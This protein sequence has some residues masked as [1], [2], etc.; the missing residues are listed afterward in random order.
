[1]ANKKNQP[2]LLKLPSVI[3]SD[4]PP[5]L[6]EGEGC[7]G[8]VFVCKM[9]LHVNARVCVFVHVIGVS[10]RGGSGGEKSVFSMAHSEL[11]SSAN[12]ISQ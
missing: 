9:Y 2:V 6:G 7:R 8:G 3:T 12:E 10:Q 4:S 11:G 1:M 5:L